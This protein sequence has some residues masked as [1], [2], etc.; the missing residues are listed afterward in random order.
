MSCNLLAA[1]IC[2]PRA[3]IDLRR[4]FPRMVLSKLPSG[5]W[6]RQTQRAFDSAEARWRE[7]AE[8]A[9]PSVQ[10]QV[11]FGLS[12]LVL[13]QYG[14]ADAAPQAHNV[15]GNVGQKAC[16][17]MQDKPRSMPIAPPMV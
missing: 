14:L 1:V 15:E 13:P 4:K 2:T 12:T 9:G 17:L 5:A 8:R 16:L 10:A 11:T 6:V 7:E 3:R